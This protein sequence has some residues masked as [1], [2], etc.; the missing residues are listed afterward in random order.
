[1]LLHVSGSL[2][3]FTCRLFGGQWDRPAAAYFAFIVGNDAYTT[4]PRLPSCS[5]AV[6]GMQAVVQGLGYPADNVVTL[7][8]ANRDTTMATY[9]ALV[10]RV[11]ASPSGTLLL[12]F[13]GHGL[14]FKDD[15]GLV[16]VDPDLPG[17]GPN[18]D[19]VRISWLLSELSRTCGASTSAVIIVDACRF[20]V[21]SE[22][23]DSILGTSGSRPHS[24]T[25]HRAGV[26]PCDR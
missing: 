22:D 19:C 12:Y 25:P 18:F 2:C 21:E 14:Q 6:H 24:P 8:N 17:P 9:L 13:S 16:C 3:S 11:Q 26:A 10:D 4:L 20:E 1:M 7:T 5:S 23:A 15:T